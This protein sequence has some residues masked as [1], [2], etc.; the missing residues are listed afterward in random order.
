MKKQSKKIYNIIAIVFFLLVILGGFFATAGKSFSSI[1]SAALEDKLSDLPNTLETEM[2]SEFPMLSFFRDLKGG[3]YSLI[4]KDVVGDYEYIKDSKGYVRIVSDGYDCSSFLNSTIN[5]KAKLDEKNTPFVYVNL[6]DSSSYLLGNTSVEGQLPIELLNAIKANEVDVLDINEKFRNQQDIYEDFF[7]RTDFHFTT[8]GE[9]FLAKEISDYLAEQH[10]VNFCNANIV[11]S[12]D[13]Y[14]ISSYPFIGNAVRSIGKYFTQTD[15]FEVYHPKFDTSLNVFVPQEGLYKTGTFDE[16]VLNGYENNENNTEYTYWVTD[17]G[18]FPSEYYTISNN[19]IEN[20]ANILIICDS[21]F[22][23]GFSYLSLACESI[24]IFDPRVNGNSVLLGLLLDNNKYD[25]VIQIGSCD[26]YYSSSYIS[27]IPQIAQINSDNDTIRLYIDEWSNGKVDNDNMSVNFTLDNDVNVIGWSIDKEN[28][29]PIKEIYA[30]I[31]GKLIKCE[32]GETRTTVANYYNNGGLYNTGFSVTIPF[33]LFENEK[34]EDISFILINEY[35]K[36][37]RCSYDINKHDVQ[38]ALSLPT[39]PL[40]SS[41]NGT[42]IDYCNGKAQPQERLV[43]ID[44]ENTQSVTLT[45]WSADMVNMTPL[46]ALFVKVG[47]E[48]FPCSY[49]EE[50][51]SVADY[52]QNENLRYTGFT[53]NIPTEYFSSDINQLRFIEVGLDGTFRY[54]DVLYNIE[55]GSDKQTEGSSVK[56]MDAVAA[57]SLPTRPLDSPVNGTWIDYCNDVA[58]PQERYVS[59]DIKNAESVTLKG[60]AADMVNMQ[61][62]GALFICVGDEMFKCDYGEEAGSVSDYFQNENLRYTGFSVNIPAEHFSS[63]I[64]QI[65]FIEVG[66]DGTFRYEDVIYNAEI[67]G[68]PHNSWVWLLMIA[69]IVIVFLLA[70]LYL[71]KSNG[72]EMFQKFNE[73]KFLFSELIKRDFTLRYKRTVLGM[74]WSMISPLV[75]LLIMWLVFQNLMGG[76][77][78]HY[79]IYL[80]SGQLVFNFFNEATSMGMTSLLDNAGIFSK[81]N[82]PKYLFLFSRNIASLINFGLTLIIYLLFVAIDGI[83]F[84]IAFLSL[85]YPILCL[86]IMNLGIG[87]ILS[88]LYVF[89]R[90]MRYL[91][92]IASQLIMWLSVIFYSIDSM[93]PNVQKIFLLNP[94]YLCIKYFRSVVIEGVVPDLS[95]HLLMA[96]FSLGFFAAGCLI[97]KKKNHEFLYYI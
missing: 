20:G 75:N 4:G 40:D 47:D 93:A 65:S 51:S 77:I 55:Y 31:N 22:M 48:V 32:Y 16:A 8:N 54:E 88:A 63:D 1:K 10:N 90:D 71:K 12:K 83:P 61:P 29:K 56:D 69:F 95:Y 37:V 24:T 25:A 38:S 45:G 18:H 44:L 92:G 9:L 33:E 2:K 14:D 86:T 67:I 27:S 19:N 66:L 43:N 35:G 28:L 91:W 58:Q 85:L 21:T 15:N 23:R 11:F 72:G 52:F 46:G 34:V 87:M 59:I 82:V 89:F 70:L 41:V 7:F 36:I 94:V 17:F 39:R 13:E 5:L 64:K 42:W 53:V 26:D 6:P 68:A 57:L 79:V 60:W 49:G 74:M 30:E 50:A 73:N 97:Y 80:F 78:N 76:N 96:F 84:S 81:V 62:L 3:V